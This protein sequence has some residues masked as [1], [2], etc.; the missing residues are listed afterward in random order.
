MSKQHVVSG[1][2]EFLT[3][4]LRK[5]GGAHTVGPILAGIKLP[6]HVLQ[7]GCEVDEVVSMA[8]LAAID[9]EGHPHEAR[10]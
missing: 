5:L 4:L 7:K 6:I 9:A 8:A 10:K 2:L 1:G 3:P